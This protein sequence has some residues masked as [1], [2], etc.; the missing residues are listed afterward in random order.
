MLVVVPVHLSAWPSRKWPTDWSKMIHRIQL[1]RRDPI[2]YVYF[3][4]LLVIVHVLNSQILF[5]FRLFTYHR[6]FKMH[7]IKLKCKIE[8]SFFVSLVSLSLRSRPPK[9]TCSTILQIWRLASMAR[10]NLLLWAIGHVEQ[11]FHLSHVRH[12]F[13]DPVGL[14]VR[15]TSHVCLPCRHQFGEHNKFGTWFSAEHTRW[16]DS[17]LMSACH[18]QVVVFTLQ[19][20]HIDKETGE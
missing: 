14:N 7:W 1:K 3:W 10:W 19:F 4:I 11:F 16:M 5:N 2:K 15:H 9:N 20:G 13:I 8:T 6:L 12:D 17:R 18:R